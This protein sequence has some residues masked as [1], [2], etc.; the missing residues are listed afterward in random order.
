MSSPNL[1]FVGLSRYFTEKVSM[2]LSEILALFYASVDK[3]IEFEL[4]DS[5]KFEDVCG[6]DF[7][8]AT[9]KK[10]LKRVANYE[11][12]VISIDCSR[13]NSEANLKSIKNN[14]V[15]LFL[16]M[17]FEL[18]NQI[19]AEELKLSQD[20]IFIN[21]T[22]FDDR[23]RLCLDNADIVIKC[24]S[25]NADFEAKKIGHQLENLY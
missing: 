10:I 22:L 9:E 4:L 24:D 23:R 19:L 2:Q 15:V 12:T 5:R 16:D 8:E 1:C 3:L 21:K 14:C 13:L 17:D 7:L 25:N 6:K 20:V 11:N 18:Y